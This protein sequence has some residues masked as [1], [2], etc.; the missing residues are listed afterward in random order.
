LWLKRTINKLSDK[1]VKKNRLNAMQIHNSDSLKPNSDYLPRLIAFYLPQYH[2]IPENDAWWGKGFTEWANVAKA[3][4]LFDGHYQPHLPADLGFYDL[5]VPEVRIQ[6]AEMAHQFGLSGFCYWHYWFAGKQLLELPF[7]EVLKSGKPDFPFCLA[8]ANESW[9]GIWHGAPNRIL[10]NQTYPG[11]KDHINH[12]YSLL[13]AFLDDRYIRIENK[14]IFII[15]K[16]TNLPEPKKFLDIWQNLAIKNGIDGLYFL[17]YK[18]PI[19][20]DDFNG[21]Q[22]I[23]YDNL[24]NFIRSSSMDRYTFTHRILGKIDR[25]ISLGPLNYFRRIPAIFSYQRYVAAGLPALKQTKDQFPVIIPNWDNTPRSNQKG[26]VL[27]DSSPNLFQIH[28]KQ[29]I[30]LVKTRSPEK[31]IIFIKSWNE[32]GEGNYLEPD[33]VFGKGY[34]EAIKEVIDKYPND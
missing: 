20:T 3:K 25:R 34:L 6:Q 32:W 9:T 4:P 33:Q 29:A 27:K 24:Y 10:I 23:I 22:G 2:P 11:E 28:L 21:F 31:Q 17:G 18:D 12:F 7:N 26:F 8:W 19:R 30:N 5:R 16:P 14:P 15:Y 13:P 1:P